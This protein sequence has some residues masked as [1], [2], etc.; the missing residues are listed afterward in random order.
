MKNKFWK[1]IKSRR[2]LYALL[3]T[4]LMYA[5][6]IGSS[7]LW[8]YLIPWRLLEVSVW[9]VVCFG[10]LG[11]VMWNRDDWF[12]KHCGQKGIKMKN[13]TMEEQLEIANNGGHFEV[14]SINSWKGI[15]IRKG[16]LLGKVIKDENGATR[17][18]TVRFEMGDE[19]IEMNNVGKDPDYIHQYEWLYKKTWYSF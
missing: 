18:L 5:F 14:V 17:R 15:S 9:L 1:T 8:A 12:E 3:T 6:V 2:F 16:K 11:F 19:I 10:L 7:R 13:L 4:V